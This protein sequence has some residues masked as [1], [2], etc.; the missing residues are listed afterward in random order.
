MTGLAPTGYQDTFARDHLPPPE[1]WP[2]LE[3]TT[4]LLQY[5]Q[6]LNAATALLDVPIARFGADRPALR[7]PDGEVWSYGELRQRTNQIAGYLTDELGLVTGNRVLL[8]SPNNPWTVAAWLAVLKAGG[9]VVTTMAA[10]RAR[11]VAPIVEKTCPAIALVDH[12]F[13]VPIHELR[14][15]IAPD[16]KVVEYGADSPDDLTRL[17]ADRPTQFTAVD[18]AADDVALFGPTSGST[19]IP[20]ITTHFHR[21]ILSIDNT[22]GRTTLQLEPDDLVA[23]TAPFAFTFGLGMLVVFPLRAGA[24][25]FLTESATPAQLA[26]LVQAHGI[27]ALATAPT[28][29]KQILRSGNAEQLRTLRKAVSAGEHI[30]LETWHEMR[31]RLGLRIIDGIGAT[32][33]LH[34]FISAAGDDIREGATGKPVPGYRATI[35]DDEGNETGPGEIGRLAVIGPVGCRYLADDR[36]RSY[37]LN[38]WNVTGDTFTRDADGYFWYQAR[39]DNMI[40]SSGYNIGGPEVEAAVEE[41][42]DVVECAV[43]AKPDPERGSIVCAF[44]VLR[45][46]ADSDA[47]AVKEIQDFVKAHIAPYKYPRE[48][49]FVDALPRNASGKLQHFRLREALDTEARRGSAT[50]AT[51]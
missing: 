29:Y 34:I 28:A 47:A 32:E 21:D 11:E 12:R 24:C 38:G 37:V 46:G 2:A 8:R 14:D 43:V 10:L 9:I 18:T 48:V 23:C 7:T 31:E 13:A 25:A 22:F 20:K 33:M 27:T 35:L 45:A 19:G 16:L 3:F 39:T 44:V 5:P 1:Q 30:Q 36:Q 6:R 50:E 4:E 17:I 40:V 42:P 15:T 51:S 49:R 41:H 26:D